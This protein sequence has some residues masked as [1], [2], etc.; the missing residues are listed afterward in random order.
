MVQMAALAFELEIM[1]NLERPSKMLYRRNE[2]GRGC[3][4][5]NSSMLY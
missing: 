5:K 3:S 4:N 2:Q 1:R